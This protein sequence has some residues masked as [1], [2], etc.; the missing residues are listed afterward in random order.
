MEKS[1]ERTFLKIN[2]NLL[3]LKY[4]IH[5]MRILDIADKNPH[6]FL[7][8]EGFFL[9]DESEV[10]AGTNITID[11]AW[12]IVEWNKNNRLLKP[13]EHQF[14]EYL[15][16]LKLNM[17]EKNKYIADCLL[18]KAKKQGFSEILNF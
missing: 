12:R 9:E 6:L 2:I 17:E 5:C 18:K 14:L 16:N 10:I 1:I 3:K 15:A 7:D 13:Q 8:M 11:L 4:V